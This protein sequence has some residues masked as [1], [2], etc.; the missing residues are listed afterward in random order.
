MKSLGARVAKPL[1]STF[2]AAGHGS[3]KRCLKLGFK[4]THREIKPLKKIR[5]YRKS[6]RN[7][8]FEVDTL[9]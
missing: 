6:S 4:D 2:T 7:E 9:K 8:V 3:E 1:L 5:N